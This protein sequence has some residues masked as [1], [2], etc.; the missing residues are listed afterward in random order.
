[1]QQDFHKLGVE[2]MAAAMGDKVANQLAASQCQVAHKIE[3]LV[4][5][6]LVFHSQFVVERPLGTEDQQVLVGNAR[7]QA[8]LAK[9]EVKGKESSR[10]SL[11]FWRKD[12]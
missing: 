4:T 12:S 8:P 11:P 1:M 7:P 5:D 10:W 3:R 9:P 6:A 2:P